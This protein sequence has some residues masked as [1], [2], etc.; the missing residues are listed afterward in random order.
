ME[1][2]APG[3]SR[4]SS[5]GGWAMPWIWL[6]AGLIGVSHTGGLHDRLSSISARRPRELPFIQFPFLSPPGFLLR[7]S[8]AKTRTF[9]RGAVGGTVRCT[10][11][12]PNTLDHAILLRP[13]HPVLLLAF[14][15]QLLTLQPCQLPYIRTAQHL[16]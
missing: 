3:Q 2:C 16:L 7:I 11:S 8:L 15:I 6:R 5:S 12:S 1:G 4:P 9:S 13:D 14:V 10:Y